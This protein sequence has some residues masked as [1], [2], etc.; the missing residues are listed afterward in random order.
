MHRKSAAGGDFPA[1]SGNQPA[2]GT[3]GL[4]NRPEA[5]RCP[6]TDRPVREDLRAGPPT[7]RRF[8]KPA[9]AGTPA[10]TGR[11]AR[12]LN[13]SWQPQSAFWS[14]RSS[15]SRPMASGRVA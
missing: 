7:G 12:P 10:G 2:D 3:I 8:P 9:A 5:R 1:I 15:R 14:A 11:G 13:A 6:R 4:F